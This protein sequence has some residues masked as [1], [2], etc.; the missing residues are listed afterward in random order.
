MTVSSD[1]ASRIAGGFWTSELRHLIEAP[2]G[3]GKYLIF[4]STFAL[5]AAVRCRKKVFDRCISDGR[6]IQTGFVLSVVIGYVIAYAFYS[7]IVRGPRLVLALYLPTMYS[8]FWL[9]TQKEIAQQ[10]VWPL[11][12]FE[13]GLVHLHVIALAMLAFDIIFTLPEVIVTDFAGA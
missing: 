4:Y 3:Y 11:G 12:R 10:F 7:P 9:L 2:F 13:V 1:V 5:A 8:I 6:W